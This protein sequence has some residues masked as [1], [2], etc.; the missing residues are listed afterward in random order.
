MTSSAAEAAAVAAASTTGAA[1]AGAPHYAYAACS[2]HTNHA[3]LRNELNRE[4]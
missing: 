4:F 2:R 1:G 3:R